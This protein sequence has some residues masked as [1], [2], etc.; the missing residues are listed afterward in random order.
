MTIILT[1]FN[2]VMGN[3]RNLLES[4]GFSEYLYE[5][6]GE[7]VTINGLRCKII[8]MLSDTNNHYAGLPKF[9]NTSDVYVGL[10]PGDV[11]RQLRIYKDRRNYKD[12]D[13]GHEHINSDGTKFPKGVVHVQRYPGANGSDAR[14]MTSAEHQVL[15]AV[16]SYFAPFARLTP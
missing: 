13:W 5:T 12:F 15:D 11:P 14:Y 9:S 7:V 10:G 8:K 16:I 1:L 4:G 3:Q 6:V 2:T